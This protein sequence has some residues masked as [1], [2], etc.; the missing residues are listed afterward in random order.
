M[1]ATVVPAPVD[2]TLEIVLFSCSRDGAHRNLGSCLQDF[3]DVHSRLLALK[4]SL[5]GAF[6][7][8]SSV[9]GPPPG[10]LNVTCIGTAAPAAHPSGIGAPTSHGRLFPRERYTSKV[11]ELTLDTALMPLGPGEVVED[12]VTQ[13]GFVPWSKVWTACCDQPEQAAI[14]LTNHRLVFL[15]QVGILD[16]DW[17]KPS[18]YVQQTFFLQGLREFSVRWEAATIAAS[19]AT[20]W[21]SLA[22]NIKQSLPMP[23]QCGRNEALRVRHSAFVGTLMRVP[24]PRVVVPS[25]AWRPAPVPLPDIVAAHVALWPGEQPLGV[26]RSQNCFRLQAFQAVPIV[27]MVTC[28]STYGLTQCLRTGTCGMLPYEDNTQAVI[29][30]HRLIA[31]TKPSN[32]CKSAFCR[33]EDL[34]VFY[35]HLSRVTGMH[36]HGDVKV[37]P[38]CCTTKFPS[39][40][41]ANPV[42]A[43]VTARLGVDSVYPISVQVCDP[44]AGDCG[45][46]LDAP[47]LQDFSGVVSN[48][49]SGQHDDCGTGQCSGT[50]GPAPAACTGPTSGPGL[51][52]GAPTVAASV[53]TSNAAQ[54]LAAGQRRTSSAMASVAS[55]GGIVHNN[56]LLGLS[57]YASRGSPSGKGLASP[58]TLPS[59]SAQAVRDPSSD[60]GGAGSV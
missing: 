45:G 31:V 55:A 13:P 44:S 19:I 56:P 39:L 9:G 17:S 53:P 3:V 7:F 25:D 34:A 11:P 27:P 6:S 47:A 36:L 30:T 18:S 48:L 24:Q 40:P 10:T 8:P 60:P 28:G 37:A 22:L 1:S 49:L 26:L 21:G 23:W 4:A 57:M 59:G 2:A 33:P 38:S 52:A 58:P 43:S 41:C 14:V 16:G 46:L 54:V 29:T 42:E 15:F 12:V 32:A 51:G 20:P 5:P 35:T 50:A